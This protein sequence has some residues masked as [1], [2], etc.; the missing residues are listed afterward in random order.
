MTVFTN[1]PESDILLVHQALLFT[2]DTSMCIVCG[3]MLLMEVLKSW[4]LI[5]RAN[6]VSTNGQV[7]SLFNARAVKI[8]Q[9]RCVGWWQK[10]N[11]SP[12]IFRKP[13]PNSGNRRRPWKKALPGPKKWPKW[14]WRKILAHVIP[15]KN[16]FCKKIG[17][18]RSFVASAVVRPIYIRLYGATAAN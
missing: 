16:I 12:P 5:G 3:N 2:G 1:N 6:L 9:P 15:I 8:K 18:K 17:P 13:P 4:L 10:T 7:G 14:P 11:E